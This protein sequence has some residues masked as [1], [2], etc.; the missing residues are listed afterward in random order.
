MAIA[1]A[2]NNP[3]VPSNGADLKIFWG[4]FSEERTMTENLKISTGASV[5]MSY[6]K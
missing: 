2:N 1:M 4:N 3:P 5:A 6:I